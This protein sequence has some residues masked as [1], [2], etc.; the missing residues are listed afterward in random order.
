[1]NKNRILIVRGANGALV[2][3]TETIAY[4][5]PV[6]DKTKNYLV[7]GDTGSKRYNQSKPVTVREIVGYFDDN[8]GIST[9]TAKPYSIKPNGDKLAITSYGEIYI[10]SAGAKTVSITKNNVKL[11][12]AVSIN[13]ELKVSTI[14]SSSK[15]EVRPETIFN[16]AVNF[17][18]NAIFTDGT[19]VKGKFVVYKSFLNEASLTVTDGKIAV[20][21]G[22][23]TTVN[24][25]TV[26]ATT[27]KTGANS[28]TAT[29]LTTNKVTAGSNVL[30]DTKLSVNTVEATTSV[31]APAISIKGEGSFGS[32][33][34][35]SGKVNGT[36]TVT[37]LVIN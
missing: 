37:N 16:K 24:S 22:E 8:N 13:K 19:G 36:L 30:D 2:A 26:N 6:Y 21:T 17:K 10:T 31:T 34:A 20:D 25:T 33:T 28:F 18:D 15:V 12:A 3:S 35:G 4:G 5:Q 32:I 7:I 23:I 14:T 29:G 1:M 9:G 11:D 27:F